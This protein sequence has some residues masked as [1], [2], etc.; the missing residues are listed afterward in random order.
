MFA[1]AL[2]S[3]LA[4]R[5]CQFSKANSLAHC[6]TYGQSAVCFEPHKDLRHGNFFPASYKAIVANP[7]WRRRLKKVHAQSR[8]SLPRT[9]R[10]KWRELDSCMSSDALLMNIFCC[11]RVCSSSTFLAGLGLEVGEVPVFGIPARVPLMNG[12]V[13]RTEI[14]MRLGNLLVEAKLTEGAFQRAPA[15]SV[16]RYRDF[17]EV[18]AENELPRSGEY[19]LSYQ[20]IRNVLAAYASNRGFLVLVDARRPDLIDAFYA[21]LRCIKPTGLRVVCRVCTWQELARALPV[22][23]QRFLSEK[24]GIE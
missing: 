3:E 18:F 7:L 23:L 2:R 19:F 1:S 13:D 21:I 24:Y 15:A 14:D 10:G 9:D 6:S 4:S 11:P 16:M 8:A 17:Q 12:Q 5:A 22:R 20:I